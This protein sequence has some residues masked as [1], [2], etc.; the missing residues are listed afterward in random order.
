MWLFK[1]VSGGMNKRKGMGAEVERERLMTH[2][3]HMCSM[4][5][6]FES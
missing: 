3:N 2:E 5:T 4:W 6:L 1:E